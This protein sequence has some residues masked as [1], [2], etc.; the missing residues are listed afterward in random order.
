MEPQITVRCPELVAEQLAHAPKIMGRKMKYALVHARGLA[1]HPPCGGVAFFYADKPIADTPLDVRKV[2]LTNG[3]EVIVSDKMLCG[4]CGK[5]FT[6]D[7][8][9]LHIRSKKRGR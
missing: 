2:R 8:L 6:L 5:A 1:E 7:Q 3:A 4:T 9:D